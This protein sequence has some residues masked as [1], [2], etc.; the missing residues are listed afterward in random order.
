MS[1]M[2]TRKPMDS[3]RGDLLLR[4]TWELLL[5]TVV[6]RL[7]AYTSE[8]A[9]QRVTALAAEPIAG[10]YVVVLFW[11]NL[12]RWVALLVDL[13]ALG[14]ILNGVGV[15]FRV[16]DTTITLPSLGKRV[17]Y[18]APWTLIGVPMGMVALHA[19][20]LGGGWSHAAGELWRWLI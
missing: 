15:L 13:Y 1:K 14:I 8:T 2:G 19:H 7:T 12:L 16:L 20:H 18:C 9:L 11:A 3:A 6:M 17:K 4:Y 5:V 10:D